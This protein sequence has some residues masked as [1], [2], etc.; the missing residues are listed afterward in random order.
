MAEIN[1]LFEQTV[2]GCDALG[3]V[4]QHTG[5]EVDRARQTIEHAEERLNALVEETETRS[6]T[7]LD[8]LDAAGQ[9]VAE[10][11][12]GLLAMVE[13]LHGHRETSAQKL[14]ELVAA[15]HERLPALQQ[16]KAELLETIEASSEQ[17]KAAIAE[18]E[19]HVVDFQAHAEQL[20]DTAKQAME[21]F[22]GGVTEVRERVSQHRERLGEHVA[23]Y[24]QALVDHYEGLAKQVETLR[25]TTEAPVASLTAAIDTRTDEAVAAVGSTF[26]QE[27]VGR[28]GSGIES[29]LGAFDSLGGVAG[30]QTGGVHAALETIAGP[31]EDIGKILEDIQ[32]VVDLI[33]RML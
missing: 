30:E 9:R 8:T 13:Q 7:A 19:G 4:V 10:H 27:V 11:S 28:L 31:V 15:A 24:R 22:R 26:A 33:R 25:E 21:T 2:A 18:L 1:Q 3:A 16:R 14:G 5:D 29:L 20:H 32:P 17:T 12:E 6:T 23:S